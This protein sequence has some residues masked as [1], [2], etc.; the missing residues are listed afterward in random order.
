[1]GKSLLA[2]A[3]LAALAAVVALSPRPARSQASTTGLD[4]KTLHVRPGGS[5]GA[6]GLTWVTA[7]ATPGAAV[8]AA[9]SGDE[10]WVAAGTYPN[11]AIDPLPAGVAMY[12]GFAGTETS[13]S[14]RRTSPDLTVL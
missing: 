7:K 8:A 6:D 3:F 10:I 14:Q 5:D 13:R 11:T 2:T 12:G 9:Q 1:M 4:P